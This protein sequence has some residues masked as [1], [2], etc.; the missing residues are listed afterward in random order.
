VLVA[1]LAAEGL[2]REDGAYFGRDEVGTVFVSVDIDKRELRVLQR[3]V[4]LYEGC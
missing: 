1:E 3:D 2:V 4:V